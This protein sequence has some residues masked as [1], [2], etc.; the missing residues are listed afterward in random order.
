M[1]CNALVGV[2]NRSIPA[3]VAA[4]VVVSG[5]RAEATDARNQSQQNQLYVD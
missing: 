3:V 5:T 1:R 2:V 4:A